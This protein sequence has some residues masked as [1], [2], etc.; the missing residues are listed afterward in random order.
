V[1]ND[2][3]GGEVSVTGLLA[4]RDII[5]QLQGRPLGS[6][7]LLPEVLCKEGE[8]RFLDDL[9]PADVE[10]ELGVPVRII[11]ATPWGLLEALE[12]MAN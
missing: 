11:P 9:T 4:G 6:L 10:R 7:L 12:E 8:E 1:R 2:F 5:A 3:F